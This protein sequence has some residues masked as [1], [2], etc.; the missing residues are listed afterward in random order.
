MPGNVSFNVSLLEIDILSQNRF[1][2]VSYQKNDLTERFKILHRLILGKQKFLGTMKI[3]FS[4]NMMSKLSNA[5][6]RVKKS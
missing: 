4:K 5:L 3:F 6:S 1:K 2:I